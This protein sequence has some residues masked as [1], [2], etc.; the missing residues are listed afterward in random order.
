MVVADEPARIVERMATASFSR[1]IRRVPGKDRGFTY[2]GVTLANRADSLTYHLVKRVVIEE[3][4]A[5]GTTT[6]RYVADL[7]HA[8]RAPSARLAVYATGDERIA[9]TVTPTAQVVPSRRRGVRPERH[10]LV[11]HSATKGIIVTGYQVSSVSATSIPEGARWL[12]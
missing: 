9:V 12:R 7:R 3:Q 10:V 4:W 2:R 6:T 11:I 1:E 8:V 5:P